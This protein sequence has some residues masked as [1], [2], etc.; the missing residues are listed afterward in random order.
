MPL[1]FRGSFA[2]GFAGGRGGSVGSMKG[3]KIRSTV[4]AV[5]V[6]LVGM[7]WS[8]EPALALDRSKDLDQFTVD[9]WGARQGLPISSITIMAQ[10]TDGYLWLGT[11]VGL[12]R[13]D[14][15]G[16]ASFNRRNTPGLP[17]SNVWA[18]LGATSG[19]LWIGLENGG[20]SILR[21]G[22]FIP[23]DSDSLEDAT[24][25]ALYEDATGAVWIGTEDGR[26]FRTVVGT[27]EPVSDQRGLGAGIRAFAAAGDGAVWA[28]T[29]GTGLWRLS[30]DGVL[31]NV[32]S[33][34]GLPS[35]SLLSLADGRNGS[36][37]IGTTAAGAVR[38][39]NNAFEVFTTDHG[40]AHNTINGIVVDDDTTVWFAT[41]RGLSRFRSSDDISTLAA[42]RDL[43]TNIVKC[44]LEDQEGSLWIGT[45]GDG[46]GRLK[47][48][49][50]ATFTAGQG[51]DFEHVWT[52]LEDHRQDLWIGTAGGGLYRMRNERVGVV[53][54]TE[55]GLSSNM[56]YSLSETPDGDLWV[57]TRS[58]LNR[59]RNGSVQIYQVDDGLPD[60]FIRALFVDSG[61]RLWI[62]TRRGLAV[63]ENERLTTY[64]LGDGLSNEVI[65]YV[66]EGSDGTIWIGTSGG[67]L[68]RLRD[69]RF[70]TVSTEDEL[71]TG[72]V[73]TIHEDATGVIWIGTN[74]GLGRIK[75]D[76]VDV[77]TKDNGLPDDFVY[78]LLEDD[79]G[80]LWAS[81]NRGVVAMPIASLHQA[82]DSGGLIERIRTFGT[83]DGMLNVECNGGV[84]PAGWRDHDGRLWFPTVKGVVRVDPSLIRPNAI[85]PN[86]VI[87]RVVANTDTLDLV[88]GSPVQMAPGTTRFELHYAA[89]SLLDPTKVKYR[90]RL[91]GFDEDW[92]EAGPRRTAYYTNVPPGRYHFE[93][94]GCNNDGV[95]STR[96][97]ALE[98]EVLPTF[99]QTGWMLLIYIGAAV[100]ILAVIV[101]LRWRQLRRRE[102]W[103][104]D[105]VDER[106]AQ[107]EDA[108]QMLEV[109]ANQDPLTGIANRRHFMER[110]DCEW[111][112]STRSSSWISLIIADIDD[113][114]AY[115]DTCGHQAGDTC[116]QRIAE[117]FDATAQR[118]ADVVA[119]YGGEEFIVLLPET[120]PDGAAAVAEAMRSDVAAMEI[121]HD[122]SRTGDHVTVSFGVA[123]VIPE[124]DIPSESL[125]KLA[126]EALYEAKEAGRN[127]TR[128]A[129]PRDCGMPS[130]TA[131]SPPDDNFDP[132]E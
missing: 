105:L 129:R 131:A 24:V 33:R 96:N 103:L 49:P 23:L 29:E 37:W 76:R 57:G 60:D 59:I 52:V 120:D 4:I 83:A 94:A 71:P 18:L 75:D 17:T 99:L 28:A 132:F 91:V 125:I 46:L 123:G 66:L 22:R 108:N 67:G 15:I 101:M 130:R 50:A 80:R 27:V 43:D 61:D 79:E 93:V 110:F 116:L 54:T 14:G 88:P 82:I 32:T 81:T 117:R 72:Y 122:A 8:G 58:G 12:V 42:R 106:T 45:G 11:Q 112:R 100:A 98:I 36:L 35:D 118:A 113:F 102:A 2:V 127:Q 124:L 114:K 70:Q 6:I 20:V 107:L 84:Q 26:V 92:T 56:V 34:N 69:G 31:G 89:L 44:L 86:V 74:E 65:R 16:T 78:H 121:R 51:L 19:E 97:A 30:P 85:P 39:R 62:G 41:Q 38:F 10:T 115:N 90:Y 63:F 64:G 73:F 1:S 5:M 47:D 95:W 119:R 9:V 13:F 3:P 87:E 55:N 68:N 109:L 111:K 21:G 126:D 77:L 128:T 7:M 53:Y 25:S 104:R 48:T 40:L